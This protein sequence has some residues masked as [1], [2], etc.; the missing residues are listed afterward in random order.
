MGW[1]DIWGWLDDFRDRVMNAPVVE[2]PPGPFRFLGE[3]RRALGEHVPDRLIILGW[4]LFLS[5]RRQG[6][7]VFWH[8]S[9]KFHPQDRRPSTRDWEDVRRIAAHVGALHAAPLI[10]QGPRVMVHWA[11]H[12][13][14]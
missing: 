6:D 2:S 12:E 11:W 13:L 7:L 4:E 9:A 1:M 14:P 8:L 3:A 10:A 5:R